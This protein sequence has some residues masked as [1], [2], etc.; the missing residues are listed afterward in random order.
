M[1][2]LQ[3]YIKLFGFIFINIIG[4]PGS[5]SEKFVKELASD[6]NIKYIT[7]YDYM[8]DNYPK[9]KLPGDITITNR[10][11]LNLINMKKLNEDID[12][13]SPNGIILLSYGINIDLLN[14]KPNITI[15]IDINTNYAIKNI[16]SKNPNLD[17][18]KETYLFKNYLLHIR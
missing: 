11:A 4:I 18:K 17:I 16:I 3:A 12:I 6:L 8:H 10:Y 7:I 15:M 14:I 9:L 2:I 1:N 13:I 5:Q